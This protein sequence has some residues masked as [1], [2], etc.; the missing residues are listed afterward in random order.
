MDCLAQNDVWTNNSFRIDQT[1]LAHT[2]SSNLSNSKHKIPQGKYL[3]HPC[4]EENF[5]S[6]KLNDPLFYLFDTSR[7]SIISISWIEM[8]SE[9]GFLV[10]KLKTLVEQKSQFRD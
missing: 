7:Y 4:F 5:Y 9:S 10:S 6:S 8:G 3:Y 1:L 2:P